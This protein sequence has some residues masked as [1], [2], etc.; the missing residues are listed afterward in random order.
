MKNPLKMID[1]ETKK[2]L[3]GGLVGSFSYYADLALAEQSWY[4]S[5]LKSSVSSK[6]P[7]NDE[8]LTSIAPPVIMYVAGKKNK[9]VAELA[10]GTM[11]YSIPH[12]ANRVIVDVAKPAT[13]GASLNMFSAPV[14]AP[15]PV[16]LPAPMSANDVVV[17]ANGYV[18]SADKIYPAPVPVPTVEVASKSSLGK[19]R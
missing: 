5:V 13:V 9:K 8:L 12:L 4:P 15:L 6:L 1:G 19:Y 14:S 18:S 2:L 10:K 11:M 16:S 17:G 3:L 7:R